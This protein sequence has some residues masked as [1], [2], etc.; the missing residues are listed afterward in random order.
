VGA[1]VAGRHGSTLR[2]VP[3]PITSRVAALVAV[4]SLVVVS[5]TSGPS[6]SRGELGSEPADATPEPSVSIEEI[7][8]PQDVVIAPTPTPEGPRPFRVATLMGETGVL[9]PLDGPAIAGVLSEVDRINEEGGLLGRPIEVQRIDTNSR[10]GLTERLGE[11]LVD[12]PPDL[13]VTSCDT[14]LSRPMLELAEANDLLTISPCASDVRYLTGGLGPGNFTMGAPSES[15]GEVAATA[16]FAR[17]GPTAVVLRDVTSPEA[18]DFCNGFERGYR[19]LGG[20]ITHEDEFSYDTLEPVQERLEREADPSFFTVCSHVPGGVD[21]APAII[22]MIRELGYA[23]P[24][25]GG[26]TLDEPG[27]FSDVPALGELLFVSWSSNYGNDPD[28]RVNALVRR[29]QQ[30][31]DLLIGAGVS[32]I[33][34]A[35]TIEAWARA[36]EAAG[37]DDTERVIAELGAFAGEQFATGGISFA[38]GARMDLGRAFRILQV[39][40]GQLTVLEVVETDD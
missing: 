18:G 28:D 35:E 34:G 36:V 33:L 23:A 3:R 30:R 27:W 22:S 19:A 4:S 32:T 38:D 31:S 1:T 10:A 14:E 17:Y 8:A 11:R 9:A 15:L 21:G 6:T 12:D 37:S 5:C 13:I 26:S 40:E 25:V 39:A 16:A 24:I 29:V 7:S 20:T 2:A